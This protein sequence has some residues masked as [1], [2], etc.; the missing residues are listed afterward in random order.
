MSTDTSGHKTGPRR[1]GGNKRRSQLNLE[2][3]T[4]TT[5]AVKFGPDAIS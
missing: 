5:I 4:G 3:T 1:A 2:D